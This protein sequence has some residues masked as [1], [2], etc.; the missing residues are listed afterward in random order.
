M[1]Y[2]IGEVAERFSL[3]ISTLRY[4][5][6]EGLFPELE[7]SSGIRQFSEREIDAL[8][9]IECL[10]KSGLEIKEIRQ[11]MQWCKEG[12]TTY[13]QR[14]RLFREQQ[15]KVAKELERM[16]R[17]QDMLTF[18]CWY[19]EQLLAGEREDELKNPNSGKMPE[20][21]QKAFK[22]AFTEEKPM[23]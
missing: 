5:D 23:P 21:I 19:Y 22:N 6:K 20:G 15:Q 18:K 1:T 2:T 4:Y 16:Q 9:V 11:F 13:R 12:N 8:K 7:R 3:S 14:Y 10:K 17:V